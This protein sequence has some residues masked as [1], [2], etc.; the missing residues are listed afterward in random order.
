MK[1][2]HFINDMSGE[3]FDHLRAEYDLGADY[4]LSPLVGLDAPS[5]SLIRH[6][7]RRLSAANILHTHKAT[8]MPVAEIEALLPAPVKRAKKAA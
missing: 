1:T 8:G 7:K 4:K 2:T 3:L 6:G 5:I